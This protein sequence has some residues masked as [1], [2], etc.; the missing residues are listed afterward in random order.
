MRGSG[1]SLEYLSAKG[2]DRVQMGLC[3]DAD[4]NKRSYRQEVRKNAGAYEVDE[5]S[6]GIWLLLD[7]KSL[8]DFL[9]LDLV[10]CP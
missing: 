6:D 3:L 2:A 1:P 9:K 10:S 4:W 5:N 7:E 8:A